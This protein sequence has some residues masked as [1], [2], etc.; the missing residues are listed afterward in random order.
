MICLYLYLVS[1]EVGLFFK[2]R[3]FLCL[4][5]SYVSWMIMSKCLIVLG[6]F[7]FSWEM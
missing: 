5:I 4:F 3:D 7:F 6:F 1:D 2:F